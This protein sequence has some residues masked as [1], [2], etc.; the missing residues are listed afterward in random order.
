MRVT[1][2]ST[3][4]CESWCDEALLWIVPAKVA[5]HVGDAERNR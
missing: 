5:G 4:E 2:P 3:S 1:L